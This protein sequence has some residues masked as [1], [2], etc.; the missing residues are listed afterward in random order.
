ME[1]EFF[2]VSYVR[3][4]IFLTDFFNLIIESD[5][6]NPNNIHLVSQRLIV[7]LVRMTD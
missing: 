3:E 1:F 4:Y 6:F 5:K 2:L 7:G